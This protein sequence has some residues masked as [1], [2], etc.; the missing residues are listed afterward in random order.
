MVIIELIMLL[1]V[2]LLVSTVINHYLPM[3]PG[4]LIQI[5][6]GLLLSVFTNF[7][8]NFETEWFLLLFIAPLL[9][10]DGKRFPKRELWQLKLP[11]FINAIALVVITM[12]FGGIIIN[13]MIPE[14]PFAVAFA[15]AAI[16]SPTD[17]VA[18]QSI[19]KRSNLPGSI[20]H[21][22]SGESL[23]NDAS[24]LICFKY[25]L[26]AAITGQFMLSHAI[27]DFFYISVVGLVAGIFLMYLLVKLRRYL[28]DHG[29]QN[30]IF[31]T[32]AYI[33]TPFVIYFISEDWLHASGVISVVSAGIT[34]HL[35]SRRTSIVNPELKLVTEK[36]W[37]VIIYILNGIIFLLLGF[38]LPEAM[39]GSIQT[40][41]LGT[42]QPIFYAIVTWAVLLLI[43]TLWIAGYQLVANRWD[44]HQVNW[45]VSI[46]SGLSGVRGAV[47]MV[48]VLSI[49]LATPAGRAFPE[50]PLVLFIAAS[51]IIL[52][53][54]SAIILIPLLTDNKAEVIEYDQYLTE[55]EAQAK[56]IQSA[57]KEI[58]KSQNEHN[59]QAAFDL[60][61][62]YQLML[63]KLN[64]SLHS[65]RINDF[66]FNNELAL[67]RIAFSGERK[68]ALRMY[69]DGEIKRDEYV[70][71]SQIIN[72]REAAMFDSVGMRSSRS[73]VRTDFNTLLSGLKK[74]FFSSSKTKH[75]G[76]RLQ[77]HW[78]MIINGLSQSAIEEVK[79]YL[80]RDD[81]DSSSFEN[82]MVDHIIVFY[83]NRMNRVNSTSLDR[84]DY[85]QQ[86]DNLQVKGFGAQ[87][88]EV[89][90]LLDDKQIDW[91]IS[92][93]LRQHVNYLENVLMSP[94]SDDD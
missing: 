51:V 20:L 5:G 45:R 57:I 85:D 65:N 10:N 49:P 37:N 23:I 81:I 8:I 14:M 17:P 9:F 60:I 13:W 46:L 88:L 70:A 35:M 71:V 90:Q 73:T 94:L 48:G 58:H 34:F 25:A 42:V 33:L 59:Q 93:D 28:Y 86:Y 76:E 39:G 11:I 63:R 7:K 66:S 6:L 53:L 84:D 26:A 47:T 21:L 80:N 24:G 52:S 92:N 55:D 3:I 40:I 12:L 16:L 54:L 82:Q 89:Q 19:A 41:Q 83:R 32:V 38:S 29:M 30:I 68:A 56:M 64:H 62:Q 1:V 2:L 50:R 91:S 75:R 18:V 43:R 27:G 72:R 15:L 61:F 67:R 87:R 69:E 31:L 74:F 22:V 77:R 4:S 36:T 79:N 44:Y 78:A